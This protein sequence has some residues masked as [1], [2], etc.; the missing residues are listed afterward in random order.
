[1]TQPAILT[2][3]GFDAAQREA[4]EKQIQV[5]PARAWYPSSAGHPCDRYAVFR[6]TRWNEMKPHDAGTQAIFNEGN[7]HQPAIYAALEGIGFQL[8]RESDRPRQWKLK[9]GA[10]I[11]GRIDGKL[12]GF[13]G[14]K[15]EAPR[16]LEIKTTQTYQFDKLNTYTDILTS[17]QHYVRGYAVQAQL[18]C[19]LEELAEGVLV[20]KNKQNGLLKLIPYSLDYAF[21][22]GVVQ[23]IERLNA[24]VQR[25]ESPPPITYDDG[26][27]GRCGFLGLCYPPKDYGAGLQLFDDS[28]LME[29]L[30]ALEEL[31]KGAKEYD[32]L[33]KSIK[34]RL[35]RLGTF[36]A[37]MCGP[38]LIERNEVSVKE[39]NVKARTDVRFSISRPDQ[40]KQ[41][42]GE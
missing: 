1:M 17:A 31:K 36:E 35:K 18:Y 4:L 12:V 29:D 3:E 11:S 19:L 8:V 40:P 24:M 20:F 27:C 42:E 5:Y 13:R 9:G 28:Q 34:A 16:L 41:I 39:Y 33:D 7:L 15:F 30:T 14:E 23:R 22:E 25:K 21:A 26:V 38:Y 37:A 2:P 10:V 32:A 6:W